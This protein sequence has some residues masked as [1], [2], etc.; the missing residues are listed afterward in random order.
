M[1]PV[2]TSR[3]NLFPPDVS[4]HSR[5]LC[6]SGATCAEESLAV[7]SCDRDG[8][9]M[10]SRGVPLERRPGSFDSHNLIGL[11]NNKCGLFM[12]SGTQLNPL[13]L[14]PGSL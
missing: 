1:K 9:A 5:N 4:K 2:Q 13:D 7:F 10:C 8:K 11:V 6:L 14:F 12:L 3:S